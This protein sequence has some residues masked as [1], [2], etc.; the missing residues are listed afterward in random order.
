MNDTNILI[1]FYIPKSYFEKSCIA[2]IANA[3]TI[4]ID[5]LKFGSSLCKIA[6]RAKNVIIL[7]L[8]PKTL[9]GHNRPSK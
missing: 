4:Q 7:K 9:P 5:V 2:I 1:I 3:N 6:V 8:N